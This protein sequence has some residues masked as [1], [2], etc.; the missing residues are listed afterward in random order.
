MPIKEMTYR[1]IEKVWHFEFLAALHR[2]SITREE[3]LEKTKLCS[4][5]G[6]CYYKGSKI[7]SPNKLSCMCKQVGIPVEEVLSRNIP[8]FFA[9][10][11]TAQPRVLS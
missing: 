4:T 6:S 8:G 1:E 10:G 5:N 2:R 11:P 9:G 3:F 7:A